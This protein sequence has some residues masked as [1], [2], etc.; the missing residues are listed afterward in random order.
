M[1]RKLYKRTQIHPEG[2]FVSNY[3]NSQIDSNALG[4]RIVSQG[5]VYKAAQLS[6]NIIKYRDPDAHSEAIYNFINAASTGDVWSE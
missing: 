1:N 2:R 5:A 4:A 3:E 6:S